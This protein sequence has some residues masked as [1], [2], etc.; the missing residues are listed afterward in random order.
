M[1]R[2]KPLKLR[3]AIETALRARA[4]PDRSPH[5]LTGFTTVQVA[6]GAGIKLRQVPRKAWKRG[7]DG[8]GYTIATVTCA[9]G[10]EPTA[11][12]AEAPTKCPGCERWFFY[13]SSDV[14]ALNSPAPSD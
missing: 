3:P 4:D 10:G 8:D 1:P 7:E 2:P 12:I 6:L 11:Y 5:Q 9:C 14:W 13:D